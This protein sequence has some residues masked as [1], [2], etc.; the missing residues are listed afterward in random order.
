VRSVKTS[1]QPALWHRDSARGYQID[2]R[3]HVVRHALAR[4]LR[5]NLGEDWVSSRIISQ[6]GNHPP[7]VVNS[8]LRLV[9]D[10]RRLHEIEQRVDVAAEAHHSGRYLCRNL[11]C[12]RDDNVVR[13][14]CDPP[15]KIVPGSEVR[16]GAGN[17]SRPCCQAINDAACLVLAFADVKGEHASFIFCMQLP[18]CGDHERDWSLAH[19]PFDAVAGLRARIF[20]RGLM[21]DAALADERAQQHGKRV[22]FIGLYLIG[23]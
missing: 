10:G 11:G 14:E 1:H 19:D 8:P 12:E 17:S 13:A 9:Q 6:C 15:L 23:S 7:A 2:N 21:H 5:Q 20:H 18:R 4:C 16:R 22:V 3:T